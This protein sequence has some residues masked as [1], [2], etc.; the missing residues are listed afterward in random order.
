MRACAGA[1]NDA[2]ERIYDYERIYRG[3]TS[4]AFHRSLAALLNCDRIVWN[5]FLLF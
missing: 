1:K 5:S 3:N 4:R 2:G